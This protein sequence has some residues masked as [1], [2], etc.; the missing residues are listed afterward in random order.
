MW[1]FFEEFKLQKDCEIN[2]LIK[3]FLGLVEM[4]LGLVNVSFSLPEWQAVKMIFFAPCMVT[5]LLH[6]KNGFLLT[7]CFQKQATFCV[8]WT[9]PEAKRYLDS[10]IHIIIIIMEVHRERWRH[11]QWPQRWEHSPRFDAQMQPHWRHLTAV[12]GVQF[13]FFWKFWTPS[14]TAILQALWSVA[15]E[16]FPS[17]TSVLEL[18]LS[19]QEMPMTLRGQWRWNS[20]S[21]KTGEDHRDLKNKYHMLS[22]NFALFLYLF[23]STFLSTNVTKWYLAQVMTVQHLSG[24]AH[25]V[26]HQM[27]YLF[28]Q[29]ALMLFC[30]MMR[31]HQR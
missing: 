27:K 14:W 22:V 16:G 24:P 6:Y 26:F 1:S 29:V 23:C 4:M 12:L 13:S 8:V 9:G 18:T 5:N 30:L 20:L 31:K 10:Y 28:I 3:T 15:S 21:S 25:W 11:H 7:K 17:S 2:L 19:S